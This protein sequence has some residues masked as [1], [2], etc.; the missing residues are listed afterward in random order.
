MTIQAKLDTLVGGMVV[1]FT[2]YVITY[3]AVLSPVDKMEAGRGFMARPAE[4]V[5]VGGE[6]D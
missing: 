4:P 5:E 1:A 2:F 3:F 6:K